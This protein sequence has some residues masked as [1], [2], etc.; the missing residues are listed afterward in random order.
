MTFRYC[1][2][3]GGKLTMRPMGD[4]G[5]KPFCESCGVPYFDYVPVCIIAAVENSSGMVAIIKQNYVSKVNYVLVAGHLSIG[6]NA[7]E[8]CAREVSEE[9]GVRVT[10]VRYVDSFFYDKRELLMLGYHVHTDSTEFHCSSEVDLA[11]WTTP[12]DA[13]KKVRQKGTA[14]QLLER[15]Y[16]K[17]G[18]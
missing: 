13:I 14:H 10:D 18:R 4:D 2:E 3:C 6:E 9:L 5:D 16:L 15:L 17:N 7:E 8:A 12:L 11:E 1:P